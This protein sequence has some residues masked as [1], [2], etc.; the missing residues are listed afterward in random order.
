MGKTFKVKIEF[1]VD[2]GFRIP[3][4]I[5]VPLSS[6]IEW[7]ITD[8][9]VIQS[10]RRFRHYGLRFQ[11]YLSGKSPFNWESQFLDIKYPNPLSY[12]GGALAFAPMTQVL[13][14][15]VVQERGDYKYGVKVTDP[16]SDETLYDEDPFIHVF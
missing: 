15:G 6:N 5:H 9:N 1:R 10:S 2:R 7:E 13:A 4:H 12:G 16:E 14:A 8:L 11:L 3:E